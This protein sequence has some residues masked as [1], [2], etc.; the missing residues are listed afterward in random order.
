MFSKTCNL[1]FVPLIRGGL[2]IRFLLLCTHRIPNLVP[3]PVDSN[4]VQLCAN[5]QEYVQHRNADEHFI[6]SSVQ[7]LIVFAVDVLA[8]HVGGLDTHVIK[9]G[10]DSTSSDRAGVTR[11][12][13]DDYGVDVRMSYY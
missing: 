7:R 8:Y 9:G 5:E 13:G 12:D 11:G 6:A 4:I 10:C 1:P 2:Q 3:L